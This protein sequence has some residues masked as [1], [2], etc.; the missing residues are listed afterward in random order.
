VFTVPNALVLKRCRFSRPTA[1]GGV[2]V[3]VHGVRHDAS[4]RIA[5][6]D[7]EIRVDTDESDRRLDLLHENVKK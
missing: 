6:I 3:R 4:P 7:S 5:R 1:A 2:D